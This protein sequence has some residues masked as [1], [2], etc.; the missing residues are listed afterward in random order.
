MNGFVEGKK[1]GFALERNTQIP[2]LL[3]TYLVRKVAK[4]QPFNLNG[5]EDQKPL[6]TCERFRN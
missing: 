3:H 4:I 5:R 6:L 2:T 1:L